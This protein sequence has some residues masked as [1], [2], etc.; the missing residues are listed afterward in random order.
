[1]EHVDAD[2]KENRMIYV[3]NIVQR[4]KV[5]LNNLLSDTFYVN[6][7][8]NAI[9]ITLS[10]ISSFLTGVNGLELSFYSL[11]I[12]HIRSYCEINTILYR[13]FDELY[14]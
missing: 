1:M 4:K 5:S 11:V 8:K 2:G 10:I 6:K 3:M 7:Y 13:V 14:D 9:F 12:I